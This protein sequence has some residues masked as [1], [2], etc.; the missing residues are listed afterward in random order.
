MLKQGS[1][2]VQFFVKETLNSDW[3]M[4][5]SYTILDL[6]LLGQISALI[7][8]IMIIIGRTALFEP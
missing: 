8:I 1:G 3:L 6:D 4:L 5:T 2:K 7:V